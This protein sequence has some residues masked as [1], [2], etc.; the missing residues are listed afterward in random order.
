MAVGDSTLEVAEHAPEEAVP[1][2]EGVELDS[3]EAE[4]DSEVEVAWQ[5]AALAGGT[6]EHWREQRK[7]R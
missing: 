7:E 5:V 3:E 1:D 4:L 2:A 6:E